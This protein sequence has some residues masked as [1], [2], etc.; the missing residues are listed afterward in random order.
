M[1]VGSS[2]RV[3]GTWARA[4]GFVIPR[5]F[6]P[7]CVG[8]MVLFL[9]AERLM[10]VHPHVCGEHGTFDPRAYRPNGSSPRVWGTYCSAWRVMNRERFIPT[11]VGNIA[12][13]A[14]SPV[15]TAVHPHVCG[16][17]SHSRHGFYRSAGSSPRVWGTSP[18]LFSVNELSRFIPTCVGNMLL[19]S[20]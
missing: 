6:I 16:E 20:L 15:I 5:R 17:H 2:P 8:N 4:E 3:W 12:A 10:P 7:T 13:P 9:S 1:F 19:L 11:C 14:S 18:H